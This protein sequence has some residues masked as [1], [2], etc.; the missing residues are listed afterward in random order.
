MVQA[1]ALVRVAGVA[2]I[3]APLFPMIV[4][5]PTRAYIALPAVAVLV[6][7]LASAGEWIAPTLRV[8]RP[9]P[10]DPRPVAQV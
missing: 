3:L 6:G 8:R 9:R 5:I 4:V 7:L 10:P 2:Q 1:D